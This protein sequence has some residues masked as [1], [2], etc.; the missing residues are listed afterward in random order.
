M[1]DEDLGRELSTAGLMTQEQLKT[2]QEYQASLGG[3]LAD[4]IVKLGFVAEPELNRVVARCERVH[5]LDVVGRTPDRE[6]ME[7]IPRRIIEEHLVLPFRQGDDAIL[8]A[9][10][11]ATDFAVIEEIQFLTNR[12]VESALAPRTQIREQIVRYYSEAQDPGELQQG[13]E[14]RLLQRIA[15]PTVAALARVLL[16]RGVLDA[17]SWQR[18]LD[19]DR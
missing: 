9:M 8:L 1:T 10:S 4:I 19:R 12:K 11:E 18:E 13:L 14:Q 17:E 6:L 16:E 2:A 5:S 15:D 3:R 7:L